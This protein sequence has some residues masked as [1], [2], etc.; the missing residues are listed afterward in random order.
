[1]SGREN[2]GSGRACPLHIALS[3]QSTW[4]ATHIPTHGSTH[5]GT[6]NLTDVLTNGPT[7]GLTDGPAHGPIDGPTD[8]PAHGTAHGRTNR[9]LHGIVHRPTYG[10]T[11]RAHHGRR[12]GIAHGPAHEGLDL[13]L[14]G[15]LHGILHVGGDHLPHDVGADPPAAPRAVP[16]AGGVSPQPSRLSGFSPGAALHPCQS[17]PIALNETEESQA[18]YSRP[19]ASDSANLQ[20]GICG[21]KSLVAPIRL[22]ARILAWYEGNHEVSRLL[23]GFASWRPA[24]FPPDRPAGTLNLDRPTAG[25]LSLP[26]YYSLPPSPR[27]TENRQRADSSRLPSRHLHGHRSPGRHASATRKSCNIA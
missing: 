23:R 26:T 16:G 9:L 22:Q 13:V 2:S 12:H 14:H 1:M 21:L 18:C 20:S 25:G 8:S 10:E 24:G 19:R 4:L 27:I 17:T 6:N 5:G 11:D 3:A 15:V 7:H